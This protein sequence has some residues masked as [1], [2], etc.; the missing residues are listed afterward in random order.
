MILALGTW[1]FTNIGV[2][3]WSHCIHKRTT[4][5]KYPPIE[6]TSLV[7]INQNVTTPFVTTCNL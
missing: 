2:H 5:P 1:I 4:Q 6:N 7:E 3:L